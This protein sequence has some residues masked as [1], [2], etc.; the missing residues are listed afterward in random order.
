MERRS[1]RMDM[2]TTRTAAEMVGREE[3]ELADTSLPGLSIRV[4]K[5]AATWCL[6]GRLGPRQSIWTIGDIGV[7]PVSVARELGTEAKKLLKRGVDPREWLAERANGG[8]TVRTFDPLKDGMTWDQ[9]VARYLEWVSREKRPSTHNDYRKILQGKDCAAWKGRLLKNLT[10]DDVK[11]LR[12]SID[13]RSPTHSAHT[14]RVV[15]PCLGWLADTAGSGIK[16]NVAWG[17][18]SRTRVA[19]DSDE[20]E[21]DRSTARLPEIAE[22]GQLAWRLSGAG[23]PTGRLAAALIVFSA[24]RI[25]TVIAARKEDFEEVP[26]GCL[27][28]IPRRFMKAKKGRKGRAHVVP[29]GTAG[30]HV[31]RQAMANASDGSQWLFPQL[32]LWR[33][34]HASPGH[35]SRKPVASALRTSL[36]GSPGAINPHDVRRAFATYGESILHWSL[37]ETKMILDHAEGLSGDVTSEHYA[38]HD[39]THLKWGVA[40]RW[41]KWLIE[42]FAAC[43]PPGAAAALPGF[44]SE[45]DRVP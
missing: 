4:R 15:R 40:R 9:G 1:L 13:R 37:A 29:L 45:H 11:A 44:L 30:W 7:I 10:D 2:H 12:D 33:V 20:D 16:S 17:V 36:N 31:V 28:K 39:G 38:L 5:S 21:D 23:T 25:A 18:K 22:V 14:I 19:A 43:K 27:W 26:G 8:P 34:G 35:V 42:Q 41:E 6:R 3:I 24:Q 32:R